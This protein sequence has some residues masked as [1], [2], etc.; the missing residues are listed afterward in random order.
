MNTLYYRE[1][2]VTESVSQ[3]ESEGKC[4]MQGISILILPPLIHSFPCSHTFKYFFIIVRS[5]IF[6]ISP[7][8]TNI[9][10]FGYFTPP[11][12]HNLKNADL[13][14]TLIYM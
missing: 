13:L 6:S 7:F 12:R 3:L 1:T 11:P 2:F 4:D 9:Q 5:Y 14:L 10:H 8:M